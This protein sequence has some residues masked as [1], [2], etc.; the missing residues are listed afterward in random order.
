MYR[1]KDEI[2]NPTRP[3]SRELKRMEYVEK[4]Q[5]CVFYDIEF[6]LN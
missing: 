5:I 1:P 3:R 4:L 6:I 2:K